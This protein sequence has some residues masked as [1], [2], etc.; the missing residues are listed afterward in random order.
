MAK[1]QNIKDHAKCVSK[2]GD[3]YSYRQKVWKCKYCK[4]ETVVYYDDYK[5]MRA[6]LRRQHPMEYKPYTIEEEQEHDDRVSLLL[7]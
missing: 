6:H 4:F 1:V 7:A 5:N 2:P 3:D